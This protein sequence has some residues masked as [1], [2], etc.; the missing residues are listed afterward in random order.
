MKFSFVVIDK[1]ILFAD[2]YT[3]FVTY[4]QIYRDTNT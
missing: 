2:K 1:D 4:K 3:S